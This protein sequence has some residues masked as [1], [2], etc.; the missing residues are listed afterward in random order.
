MKPILF[1][2]EMVRAI[3][4]GQKTV[5]RRVIKCKFDNTEIQMVNGDI[6]EV[7]DGT[8]ATDCFRCKI[9]PPYKVGDILYVRETFMKHYIFF[10]P[11]NLYN[12]RILYKADFSDADA[13][14][15]SCGI[16]RWKPSIHM[17]KEY[18]RLFLKVVNVR[19]ERLQDITNDECMKEGIQ[20]WSK[21]GKLHK[22]AIADDEGDA[23]NCEWRKCPRTPKDA[24]KII[25]DSTVK[26]ADLYR[27]GWEANPWV[28]VLEF[29]PISKEETVND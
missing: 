14:L 7:I 21:D 16:D 10:I 11:N 22:F 24:M 12:P 13:G 25:W 1:N 4:S 15:M 19:A 5:T 20:P 3:L 2:T 6:C 9:I 26:K 8:S 29:D 27:Y 28:W 23:P 17:P 18:A